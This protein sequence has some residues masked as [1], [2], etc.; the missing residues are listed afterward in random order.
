[1]CWLGAMQQRRTASEG[2]QRPQRTELPSDMN[3]RS[4]VTS[5][6]AYPSRRRLRPHPM[7][8]SPDR[9]SRLATR[10][11]VASVA[12]CQWRSSTSLAWPQRLV[13]DNQEEHAKPDQEHPGQAAT[14]PDL[15]LICSRA[16]GRFGPAH[17][18]PTTFSDTERSSATE[19]G[20][21]R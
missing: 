21:L 18:W 8:A 12:I 14:V 11:Q 17:L 9:G 4:Q 6:F 1:M 7:I 3:H 13:V 16:L 15:S 20:E 19:C 2:R 10:G 5:E